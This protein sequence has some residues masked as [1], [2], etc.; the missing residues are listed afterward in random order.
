[1]LQRARERP[2]TSTV[3]EGH[4][5][6]IQVHAGNCL[7][8]LRFPIWHSICIYM[9]PHKCSHRIPSRMDLRSS[10]QAFPY[11]DL[12][13]GPMC[14]CSDPCNV[15]TSSGRQCKI[16]P[17]DSCRWQIEWVVC[18]ETCWVPTQR[19]I[20]CLGLMHSWWCELSTD[21]MTYII[22]L[23]SYSMLISCILD[24]ATCMHVLCILIWYFFWM[25][26]A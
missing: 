5:M 11:W 21:Y 22:P 25:C 19:K 26:P 10:T 23:V 24:C 16:I 1:M 17:A 20:Q 14:G 18:R 15:S 2:D 4:R 8:R 12:C 13:C 3:Q 9:W 6:C 7:S